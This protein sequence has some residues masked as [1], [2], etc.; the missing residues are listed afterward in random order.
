MVVRNFQY[1]RQCEHTRA[2]PLRNMHVGW[3]LAPI[4][5]A[6]VSLTYVM[7]A[8][9]SQTHTHGTN[10]RTEHLSV[11][12]CVSVRQKETKPR[13]PC[14]ASIVEQYNDEPVSR[15]HKHTELEGLI[16]AGCECVC[17]C[18]CFPGWCDNTRPCRQ[19]RTSAAVVFPIRTPRL[20][21]EY[22]DCQ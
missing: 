10:K 16:R 18:V 5:R 11:S 3:N 8:I 12:A 20:V 14:V 1:L 13:V 22:S 9:Y 21:P 17:A 2:T 19:I 7:R 4:P 15:H 6:H